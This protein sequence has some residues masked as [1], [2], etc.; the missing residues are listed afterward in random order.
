M[1]NN[2]GLFFGL[3]L[4]F[5]ISWLEVHPMDSLWATEATPIVVVQVL[6]R[7]LIRGNNVEMAYQ[8]A[9]ASA[10]KEAVKQIVER[11]MPATQ[12]IQLKS[13][14][15]TRIYTNSENF[16]AGYQ[17]LSRRDYKTFVKVK[18]QVQVRQARIADELHQINEITR[19]IRQAPIGVAISEVKQSEPELT[20]KSLSLQREP[21]SILESAMIEVFTAS[22]FKVF[23]KKT[24]QDVTADFDELESP[25][26][27]QQ[28]KE[29]LGANLIIVG[30][31]KVSL[32]P[33]L[34]PYFTERSVSLHLRV[35]DSLTGEIFTAW[36]GKCQGIGVSEDIAAEDGYRKVARQA[37][38]ELIQAIYEE[39]EN[40]MRQLQTYQLVV[41]KSEFIQFDSLQTQFKTALPRPAFQ[42]KWH[43]D[44]TDNPHWLAEIETH[45]KQ[46]TVLKRLRQTPLQLLCGAE[47]SLDGD[48]ITVNLQERRSH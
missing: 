5:G 6:G 27:L 48:T 29:K 17:E 32:M 45:E 15:K 41:P 37:T 18:L 21:T 28:V 47:V 46:E 8:D 13:V 20:A 33:Q 43:P 36:E 22:D 2:I 35:Y 24:I 40:R 34:V 30:E 31:S 25:E 38:T 26:A 3:F 14:L 39:F 10:Q 23:S 9:I 11:L 4:L 19:I 12:H 44:D 42:I 7:G 16:V 1:K